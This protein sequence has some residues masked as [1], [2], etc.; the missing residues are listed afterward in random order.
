MIISIMIKWFSKINKNV[1]FSLYSPPYV[2]KNGI[3][4]QQIHGKKIFTNPKKDNMSADGIFADRSGIYWVKTA[5]CMCIAVVGKESS[6]IIHAGWKGLS[7]GI[8]K[9]IEKKVKGEKELFV[10]PFAQKCCYEFG[11][12][13]ALKH[14]NKK[15]L[16]KTQGKKYLNMKGILQGQSKSKVDFHPDCTIC[17]KQFASKRAGREGFNW[18]KMEIL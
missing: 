2:P 18:I 10:F 9:E 16:E 11:E 8:L 4:L 7:S 6:G 14:F 13:L 5:D 17:N 1:V 12:K 3:R 15:H